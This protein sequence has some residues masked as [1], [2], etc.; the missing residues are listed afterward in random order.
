MNV[1]LVHDVY[2]NAIQL[3]IRYDVP[4]AVVPD[5]VDIKL[6]ANMSSI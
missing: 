3:A 5:V 6:E 4:S 1:S 2:F